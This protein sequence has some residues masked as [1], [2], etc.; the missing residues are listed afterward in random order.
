MVTVAVRSR[1]EKKSAGI[2]ERKEIKVYSTYPKHSML[3]KG[4]EKGR[5]EREW[6]KKKRSILQ[7][8]NLW[9]SLIDKSQ[10]LLRVSLVSSMC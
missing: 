5:K 4:K 6:D 7:V 3:K 8:G 10:H 9:D 2:P 1:K